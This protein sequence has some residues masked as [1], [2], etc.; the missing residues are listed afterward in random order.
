MAAY[1]IPQDLPVRSAPLAA[2]QQA[3]TVTPTVPVK[4]KKKA[5]EMASDAA[6]QQLGTSMRA[7][8]AQRKGQ[9]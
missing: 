9:W 5:S 1:R 8:V 6:G 7:T 2:L 3:A 4:R